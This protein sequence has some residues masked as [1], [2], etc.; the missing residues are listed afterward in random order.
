MRHKTVLIFGEMGMDKWIV[1]EEAKNNYPC[2][3]LLRVM[4][5]H[6]YVDLCRLYAWNYS[7]HTFHC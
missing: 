4:K 6:T 1:E 5:D 7:R 2:E 3:K